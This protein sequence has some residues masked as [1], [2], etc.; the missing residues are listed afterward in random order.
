[1]AHSFPLEEDGSATGLSVTDISLGPGG[2]LESMGLKEPELM[3]QI[4]HES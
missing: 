1:M 3:F 4:E 2:D